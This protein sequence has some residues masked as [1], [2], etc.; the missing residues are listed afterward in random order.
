MKTVDKM[1][2]DELAFFEAAHD[3]DAKRMAAVAKRNPKALRTFQESSGDIPS[4]VD[5]MF[6]DSAEKNKIKAM[7]CLK[8]IGAN[9]HSDGDTAI[10]RAASKGADDAVRWLLDHGADI[11]H[12]KKGSNSLRAA[13]T[14]GR[15][16]SLRL[17]LSAR[18]APIDLN[19]LIDQGLSFQQ[20]SV[21]AILRDFARSRIRR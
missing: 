5:M 10:D 11:D 7:E 19:D 13:V 1:T 14:F 6:V 9:L 3:F 18:S 8:S 21:V 4:F 2:A 17:L 12:S 16:E 15:E 20:H